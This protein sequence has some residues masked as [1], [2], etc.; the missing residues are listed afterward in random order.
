MPRFINLLIMSESMAKIISMSLS[1]EL[2]NEIDQLQKEL[3]FSG[4]S[5]VIRA[6]VRMLIA[7]NREKGKLSGKLD[8]VL[9]V[10]HDQ[11]ADDIVSKLKH[12][13]EDIIKTQV[14]SHLKG[15]K[16]LEIFTLDGE[17]NRIKELTKQFQTSRKIEYMK[18]IVA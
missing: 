3:G 18:L 12:R 10:I 1:L 14:H 6:G 15:D 13:F 7:D 9:L 4:R 16:C 2:L 8:S 5:E 11:P 17:S